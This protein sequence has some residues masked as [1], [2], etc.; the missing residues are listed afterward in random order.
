MVISSITRKIIQRIG[1]VALIIVVCA[2]VLS[3]FTE[4]SILYISLFALGVFITSALNCFKIYMIE[5]TA[6]RVTNMDTPTIGKGYALI[7]YILR[8]FLTAI[9]VGVVILVMYLITGE[10]PFLSFDLE[11]QRS[12]LYEPLIIGLIV[13]LFTMK[14]A[15]ISARKM[16]DEGA[17]NETDDIIIENDRD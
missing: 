10:S 4:F 3:V 2:F 12:T 9:V 13:G 6:R 17:V 15:V 11:N 7:Q 16:L 1:L 14:I 5:R 8:Y